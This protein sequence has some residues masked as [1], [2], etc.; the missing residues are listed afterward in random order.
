MQ[1]RKRRHQKGSDCSQDQ[2]GL[3]CH[4]GLSLGCSRKVF[5]SQFRKEQIDLGNMLPTCL[6]LLFLAFNWCLYPWKEVVVVSS[7]Q[8]QVPEMVFELGLNWKMGVL[9]MWLGLETTKLCWMKL[10]G[11]VL[12]YEIFPLRVKMGLWW[13]SFVFFSKCFFL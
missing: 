2:K 11:F 4:L 6:F 12:L 5:F 9:Y 7:I 8:D 1:H 10:K 13:N 3:A